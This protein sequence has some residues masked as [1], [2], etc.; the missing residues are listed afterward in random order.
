MRNNFKKLAGLTLLFLI[1]AVQS[2]GTAV[3]ASTLSVSAKDQKDVYQLRRERK[4]TLS[5]IQDYIGTME[6]NMKGMQDRVGSV[7]G[8]IRS[9][10][11][12]NLN[13]NKVFKLTVDN[14]PVL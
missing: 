12:S 10:L 4:L 11:D 9:L 8:Q 13:K 2:P 3:E 1:A 14:L 7:L 5:K 6:Q